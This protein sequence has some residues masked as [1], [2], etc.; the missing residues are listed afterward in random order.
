MTDDQVTR[1]LAPQGRAD[2]DQLA[3]PEELAAAVAEARDEVARTDGKA[4]TLLQVATWALAGLLALV[5]ARV[6]VAAAVGLW[7]AAVLVFAAMAVLLAVVRPWLGQT[8]RNG[9]FPSSEQLLAGGH[10]TDPHAWHADRLQIF[11]RLAVAKHRLVRLG[12]DLL[13]AAIAVLALAAAALAVT[14]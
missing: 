2:P 7:T 8:P 13:L 9:I 5:H 6:P 12:V 11:A 14:S 1:T 4:G 10:V 3:P